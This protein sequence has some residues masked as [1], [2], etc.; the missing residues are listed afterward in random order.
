M[1]MNQF[2]LFSPLLIPDRLVVLL[3]IMAHCGAKP[4]SLNGTSA[5]S[6]V[7][8]AVINATGARFT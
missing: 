7:A 2:V 4:K 8:A 3:L 5:L 1:I 6:R